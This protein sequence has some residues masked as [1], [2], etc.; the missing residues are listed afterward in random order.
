MQYHTYSS[1]VVCD[2]LGLHSVCQYSFSL[3]HILYVSIT[4][5]HTHSHPYT[6]I[7]T[8]IHTPSLTYIHSVSLFSLAIY[9]KGKG[10]GICLMS[11]YI[12]K[13]HETLSF[14]DQISAQCNCRSNLRSVHQVPIIVGRQV[15]RIYRSL[16]NTFYIP[17]VL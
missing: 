8:L 5:T 14:L 3:I 11:R 9:L 2:T 1:K 12:C 4:Y 6:L 16:H 13:I 17:Q 10:K 15:M 7:H